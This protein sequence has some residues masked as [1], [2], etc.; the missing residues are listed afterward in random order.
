M[1]LNETGMEA[2]NNK[3]SILT[4]LVTY[5][6]LPRRRRIQASKTLSSPD[7]GE[8]RVIIFRMLDITSKI[9]YRQKGDDF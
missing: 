1:T 5:L 6:Y 9:L 7:P 4:S 2:G 3:V 8:Y